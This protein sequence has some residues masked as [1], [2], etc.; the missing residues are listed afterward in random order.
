MSV[1]SRYALR[2]DD[3][4][5]EAARPADCKIY[6]MN[7][8]DD[9]FA[10]RM[11]SFN[12]HLTLPP[13]V[14]KARASTNGRQPTWS[15]YA[16]DLQVRVW[17]RLKSVQSSHAVRPNQDQS[18]AQQNPTVVD[19]CRIQISPFSLHSPPLLSSTFR[20]PPLLFVLP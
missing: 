11:Q 8:D 9:V 14:R 3:T 20:Y 6:Q 13:Q 19:Y 1:P 2:L 10:K 18:H 5:D 16:A 17:N 12:N 4:H 7:N 15:A